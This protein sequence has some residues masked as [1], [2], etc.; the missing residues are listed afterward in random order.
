MRPIASIVSLLVLL[1]S[2][3]ALAA[4][5]PRWSENVVVTATLS[6]EEESRIGVAAT[7]ITRRE[8]EEH[9]A[10]TVID[11][12]RL[13]PGLQVVQAGGDGALASIFL[14]GANSTHALVLVDGVRVNSPFFAGYDFSAL[15]VDNVERIE[16]VRGPFSPLY[17]SDAMGGV[18]QVFTRSPGKGLSV[19]GTVESS[20]AGRFRGS[21]FVAHGFGTVGIG[22]SYSDSSTD[23]DRPNS[24]SRSRNGSAFASFEIGSRAT[25]GFEAAVLDARTGVPGPVG[26]ET[27][28][29]EGRFREERIAIPIRVL[30]A[31]GHE[32]SIVLAHVA[33]KPRYEDRDWG[34]EGR[35]DART[36]QLR[37]SH[38]WRTRRQTLTA[39]ASGERWEVSDESTMGSNL[40]GERTSLWGIGLEESIDLGRGWST[41]VGMRHDRH[42]TFGSAWSP[43]A[44]LAWLSGDGQWKLRASAGRAFRAPS[45]GELR[46][47]FSGNPDLEPERSTSAEV[48]FERYL[49]GGRFEATV[50]WNRFTDLI[51]FDFPTLKNQN[52]GRALTWGVELG[53]RQSLT[54]EVSLD[55]GYTWL[56]T[57]DLETGLPLLR[58]PAHLAFAG[59]VARPTSRL[60]LSSRAVFVGRRDDVEPFFPYARV[61][62]ASHV[63]WDATARMEWRHVVPYL[64]VENLLDREIE[65][66]RGYP[67][68]GRRVSAG[69]EARY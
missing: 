24:H 50:F 11:A 62:S 51:V 58:R 16:I 35:T 65:E 61:E 33:S 37:V 34:Y 12:L 52:V 20:G 21:A 13:V 2:L 23:A 56:D 43:R 6:P 14:R 68:V 53:W 17:G 19:R 57:E 27:P 26:A 9:G 38:S 5:T 41:S 36:L 44:T 10:F 8:L 67:G 15:T 55:L 49:P 30:P 59:I 63:R 32:T 7:V 60:T 29:A 69:I 3:P 42:G 47:P 31:E 39:F 54:K 46:Y 22:A 25:V 1:P 64:R 66:A 40:D 4:D 18:V 28:R 45:V 48:G